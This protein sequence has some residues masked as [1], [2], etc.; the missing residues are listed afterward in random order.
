MK[1][2]IMKKNYIKPTMSMVEL[3]T[4]SPMALSVNTNETPYNGT[5]G[6][7]GFNF[8]FAFEE[9]AVP[10]DPTQKKEEDWDDEEEDL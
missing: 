8:A 6:A 3:H 7:R 4:E 1:D 9:E 5:A 2:L 10:E